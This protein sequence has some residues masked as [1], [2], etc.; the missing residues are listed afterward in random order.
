MKREKGKQ[1]AGKILGVVC[2]TGL[3]LTGCGESTG[4][5]AADENAGKGAA[6][7]GTV[8]LSGESAQNTITVSCE[9]EVKVAPDMAQIS[10]GVYT[11]EAVADVC[12]SE[13]SQQ[14]NAV[15]EQLKGFGI[16]ES[17]IK[18]T[19]LNLNP[20]YDYSGDTQ[21]LDGYEMRT[22]ILVSDISVEASGGIL[23][24]CVEAGINNIE[25][26]EFTSG[27]YEERYQEALGKA[28]ESARK[29]AEFLAQASGCALGGVV[30]ITEHTPD[31]AARYTEGVSNYAKQEALM[32]DVSVMPGE[33]SISA[34]V[35]VQYQIQ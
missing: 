18:T 19:G 34:G 11:K 7:G 9:E 26:I 13:N 17:S 24:K 3:L 29:K 8:V 6:A 31:T 22:S 16:E 35:T 21:K 33:V 25:Y 2:I 32:A 28:V 23:A 10:F 12:V 20:V 1:R 15:V 5:A 30:E 27:D 4:Q 14:V